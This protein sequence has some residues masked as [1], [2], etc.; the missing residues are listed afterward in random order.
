MLANEA[1]RQF[2]G[3]RFDS[4]IRMVDGTLCPVQDLSPGDRLLA[5]DG[6]ENELI[7]PPVVHQGSWMLYGVSLLCKDEWDPVLIPPF[8]TPWQLLYTD[9]GY[10]S[11]EQKRGSLLNLPEPL[12]TLREGLQLTL[13]QKAGTYSYVGSL[14]QMNLQVRRGTLVDFTKHVWK[15]KLYNLCLYGGSP[16]YWVE[17]LGLGMTCPVITADSVKAVSRKQLEPLLPVIEAGLGKYT[18]QHIINKSNEEG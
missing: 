14:R 9:F 2:A 18:I 7:E 12:Y 16:S 6:T 17:D 15:G 3:I 5:V 13:F 8:F 1:L 4:Q 11:L 10:A